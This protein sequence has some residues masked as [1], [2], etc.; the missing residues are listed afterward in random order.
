MAKQTKQFQ[1]EVTQLLDLVI[2]RA[3]RKVGNQGV[4]ADP[5]AGSCS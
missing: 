2:P 4:H 5:Q 3:D 1:T